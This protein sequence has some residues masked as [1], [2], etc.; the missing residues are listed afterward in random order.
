MP[1]YSEDYLYSDSLTAPPASPLVVPPESGIGIGSPSAPISPQM[2]TQVDLRKQ[3]IERMS[4]GEKIGG[5]LGDFGAALLGRPLPLDQRIEQQRRDRLEK[6]SS[7][8]IHTDALEDGV[9]MIGKLS[10]EA[11]TSFVNSYAEQLESVRPGLGATFKTLS[12]QPDLAA[13]LSKYSAKSPTLARAIELDSTGASALKLLSSPDALKTI[14]SEI[15]SSVMPDLLR[16]GQ[17]FKMG[18]QQIVPPEMAERF[19]KDGIITAS[20]LL[21]A[22]EWVKENKPG[23]RALVLSDEDL[24]IIGRNS[25]AFYGTLGIVGPKDEAEVRKDR[26][27]Q[28]AESDIGKI[29]ADQKLGLITKKEADARIRKLNERA[30]SATGLKPETVSV[31]GKNVAVLRD[32][33]GNYFDVNTRKPITGKIAPSITEADERRNRELAG[34]RTNVESLEKSVNL[35]EGIAKKHP[36]S[37]AGLFS[38]VARG[39]EYVSGSLLP[40]GKGA[41]P[42]TQAVQLRDSIIAGMGTLGRLS[43]QDRQR[44]ENALQIGTGGNPR[45]LP[46]AIE[47]LRN[48]IRKEKTEVGTERARPKPGGKDYSNM[49]DDELLTALSGG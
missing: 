42:G 9:K 40:E 46:L 12:K 1:G 36:R 15:D 4:T 10:G 14:N 44:I 45:N 23:L 22:N 35:L 28:P 7:F 41:A 34:R 20:E 32:A 27:K 18:W 8:K 24:Q 49:S 17:T 3:A 47:I 19:K 38:P 25:E 29:R 26:L 11:R 43:N 13:V 5:A 21:E 30:E 37:A 2:P 33:Q 6:L 31:D 48:N 16:K 39:I